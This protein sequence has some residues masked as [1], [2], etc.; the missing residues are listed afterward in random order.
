MSLSS[1]STRQPRQILSNIYAFPPNRDTLGATA[2]FIV[3]K[4]AEGNPA[5]LLVD[6]PAWDGGNQTFIAAQG[7]VR[8]WIL[9][10]RGGHGAIAPIQASLQAEILVQ[11]QEAYL[12]P[13]IP[14]VQPFHRTY[15][16]GNPGLGNPGPGNSG[17]NQPGLGQPP[18]VLWTPGHS[19]GSSCLYYPRHGGVLFTGRHLLPT[20][21]G[22]LQPLRFAKTFHW[23]RQL[24]QI[25][26]LQARFT[27]DTLAYLCPG[28]N[29]GFL[30]GQR[31]V[32]HT[33]GHLQAI[34]VE[35]L[36]SQV[37]LL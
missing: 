20:P 18:E 16:L 6:T 7:G 26:Q 32:D 12:L 31:L 9:T 15:V 13:E 14:G 3:E 22:T 30:R 27:P 8:W 25:Q 34:A 35:S 4:D 1:P 33:Y 23:P 36:R 5:N 29:T 37:P 28:A 11:E 24:Q 21:Q 19:P 2:Y 10:H 17:G